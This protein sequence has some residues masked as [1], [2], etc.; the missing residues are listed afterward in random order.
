MAK[1]EGSPY[2]EDEH[3]ILAGVIQFHDTGSVQKLT[4]P[5]NPRTLKQQEQRLRLAEATEVLRFVG[6]VWKEWFIS[7]SG[8]WP[9]KDWHKI[10]VGHLSYKNS[11][12]R[13]LRLTF[14]SELSAAGLASWETAAVGIGIVSATVPEG[15]SVSPGLC[16]L[17]IVADAWE[18]QID[19]ELYP[20]RPDDNNASGWV[21]AY[22]S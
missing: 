21:A 2:G 17:L 3:P 13:V 19:F 14:L 9:A 4:E 5:R 15:L 1:V 12:I 8:G 11:A 10:W 22:M 16:L 18:Y 7:H 20:D 6:P